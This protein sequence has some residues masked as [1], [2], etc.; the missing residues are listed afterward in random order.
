M[1]CVNNC[2]RNTLQNHSPSRAC[3]FFLYVTLFFSF[4]EPFFFIFFY[5]Q[6]FFFCC[7]FPNPFLLLIP[8]YTIPVYKHSFVPAFLHF[9]PFFSIS[10]FSISISISISLSISLLFYFSFSYR[11]LSPL[12]SP[13]GFQ[14]YSNTPTNTSMSHSSSPLLHHHDAA[15]SSDTASTA[16]SIASSSLSSDSGASTPLNISQDPHVK[17][18]SK[19]APSSSF[20]DS[21]VNKILLNGYLKRLYKSNNRYHR[22][23]AILFRPQ[24]S[25]L[26]VETNR[27]SPFF[28]FYTLYV[29]ISYFT[30]FLLFLFLNQLEDAFL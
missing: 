3:I 15:D 14:M 5:F 1:R 12:L 30:V 9:F 11:C 22:F 20:Y 13:S 6:L 21:A 19:I 27:G 18:P 2:H 25:L 24:K 28:G 7:Y 4:P 10:L 23:H 17:P 16:G 26:E 29:Y 8:S